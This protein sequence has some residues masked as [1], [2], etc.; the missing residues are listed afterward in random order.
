M[1]F[2]VKNSWRFTQHQ[3]LLLFGKD[4]RGSE[5]HTVEHAKK[6]EHPPGY[7]IPQRRHV[8]STNMKI[9]TCRHKLS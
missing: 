1:S 8:T 4:R 7:E 3:P 6:S 2:Y 5:R 9:I